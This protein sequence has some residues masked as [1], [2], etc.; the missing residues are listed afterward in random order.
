MGDSPIKRPFGYF[1]GSGQKLHAQQG[2]IKV[3][4]PK[5]LNG[6]KENPILRLPL[7]GQKGKGLTPRPEGRN[8]ACKLGIV[9][10]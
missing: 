8:Q 5:R 6:T 7:G 1:C 3:R 10:K 9:E 2:G 4:N